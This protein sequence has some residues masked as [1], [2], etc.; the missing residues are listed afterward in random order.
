[1]VI[2]VLVTG[3]RLCDDK[4]HVWGVLDAIHR[5][6]GISE[7][8]HGDAR[9]ADA[10][11]KQWALAHGVP[12]R[13][14]PVP[15]RDWALYGGHAGRKRNHHMLFDSYPDLVV[16]FPG[17][18]GTNHMISLAKLHYFPLYVSREPLAKV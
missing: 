8:V 4:A 18:R 1:M 5:A 12:H 14:Y 13:P 2:K 17:R 15:D 3:G 7:V 6:K 10:L 11:A 16:A 9:G